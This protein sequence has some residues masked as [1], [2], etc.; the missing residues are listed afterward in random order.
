M[1]QLSLLRDGVKVDEF[2]LDL[3]D[4]II[5]RGRSA[6]IRLDDNQIVS[7][8][9][10]VVRERGDGHVV[11]DL[12][13]ANGTWVNGYKVDVHTL[14]PGDHIVLGPDT[15]RYDFGLRSARS[16]RDI[17]SPPAERTAA[18]DEGLDAIEELG[19]DHLGGLEDLAEVR[20][21][22]RQ[23]APPPRRVQGGLHPGGDRTA[24][25]SKDEIERLL[26]ELAL[27]QG[28]HL[29]LEGS[30]PALVIQL[31][32]GPHV[33]GHVDGCHIRLPGR[34]WF[35]G[36]IA[37]RLVKQAVGWCVVPEAPFWNPV[38]LAGE[39]IT[40]LKQLS[41][42]DVIVFRSASYRFSRGEQR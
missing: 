13:G 22:R 37:A 25:A 9:H 11:E 42:G 19:E 8:Q 28:P 30:D 39:P 36:K 27:K 32:D 31:E 5:G 20:E 16:L 7:R 10:A 24:V 21:A 33:V 40:R 3:P 18:T 38:R 12:G 6:H 2:Q 15:L 29:V 17:T 23:D 26:K 34:R 14:R 41:E 4:V 1:R 35:F